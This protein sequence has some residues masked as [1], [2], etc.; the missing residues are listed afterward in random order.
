MLNFIKR[1]F[2]RQAL[3]KAAVIPADFPAY[4]SKAI[5]LIASSNGELK[6]GELVSLFTAKGIPQIE[7]TE[8]LLFLPTAFCRHMLPNVA[9]PAYYIDYIS[10]DTQHKVPYSANLR[11]TAIQEA[12][13]AYLAGN[14]RQEDFLKIAGRSASFKAIKSLLND[15]PAFNPED[16]EIASEYVVR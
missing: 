16:V 6:D 15:S 13:S 3:P 1:V 14:F 12:M 9:W 8:L 10:E 11:Y 4:A 2:E 5:R 7:A